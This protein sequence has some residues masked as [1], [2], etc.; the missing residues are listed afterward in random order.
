MR[1]M[2]SGMPATSIAVGRGTKVPSPRSP[3]ALSPKQRAA[4]PAVTTQVCCAPA[5]S[6]VRQPVTAA[7][8]PAG[9]PSGPSGPS[10]AGGASGPAAPT[11]CPPSPSPE[12][13][14]NRRPL[15]AHAGSAKLHQPTAS[16]R[17]PAP[18][19]ASSE[20]RNPGPLPMH[21][22][23]RSTGARRVGDM[24]GGAEIDYNP[25][26]S[27]L[28]ILYLSIAV[29]TLYQGTLFLRRAGPA[30]RTYAWLLIA[31]GVLAG[32]AYVG[33]R[34]GSADRLG[35]LAGAIAIFG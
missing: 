13:S 11:H 16:Q 17:P 2:A 7:S 9:A 28:E 32:L 10:A 8:G 25:R 35:E 19:A 1:A 21:A 24:V 15:T 3:P 30:Q 12:S 29:V 6:W 18:Q 34:G 20:Q 4:P 26:T 23:S 33:V 31:D 14:P 22:A 27:V 5:A